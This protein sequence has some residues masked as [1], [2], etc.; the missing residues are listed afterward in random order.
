MTY[1]KLLPVLFC[2]RNGRSLVAGGLTL[3]RNNY[4]KLLLLCSVIKVVEFKNSNGCA[5]EIPSAGES[6]HFGFFTK[7]GGGADGYG[8]ISLTRWSKFPLLLQFSS[9]VCDSN[10][11]SASASGV[12]SIVLMVLFTGVGAVNVGSIF[13]SFSFDAVNWL[14][15]ANDTGNT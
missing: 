6:S 1:R 5:P 13:S 10:L 7:P 8:Q 4:S 11:Y 9:T 15:K 12:D 3:S 2:L 14:W